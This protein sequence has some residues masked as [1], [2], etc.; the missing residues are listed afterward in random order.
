MQCFSR[1]LSYHP[2]KRWR[3][4][5]SLPQGDWSGGILNGTEPV[6]GHPYS[7]AEQPGQGA[8]DPGGAESESITMQERIKLTMVIGL[9]RTCCFMQGAQVTPPC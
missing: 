3:H 7:P 2:G 9:L 6:G 1:S 5:A 4:P 8:E